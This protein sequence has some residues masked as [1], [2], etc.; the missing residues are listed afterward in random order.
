MNRIQKSGIDMFT[1]DNFLNKDECKILIELIDQD[2]VRSTTASDNPGEFSRVVQNRTSYTSSLNENKHPLIVQVNDKMSDIL[3]IPKTKTE[4]LQG[5]RYEVGQ[6]FKDHFD[7]FE[8]KNLKTYVE[9]QGNRSYTF[10]VY[11]NDD[12][13]GGETEFQALDIKFKPKTGMAVIWKNL[14]EDGTGNRLALHAGRPVLS[15]KKYILT[16]W[17]RQY[18]EN[19]VPEDFIKKISSLNIT[20]SGDAS[21]SGKVFSCYEDFPKFHPIGFEVKQVPE[22]TFFQLFRAYGYCRLIAFHSLFSLFIY[23]IKGIVDQIQQHPPNVLG[24]NSNFWD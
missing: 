12:L 4:A 16:R 11:L 14:N 10:M 15:G 9:K 13:E 17:F 23:G 24:D 7:W 2:A 6:E 18:E 21:P 1:I 3:N 19:K 22:K 20:T 5:Q 8:G